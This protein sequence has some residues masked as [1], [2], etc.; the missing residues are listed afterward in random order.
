MPHGQSSQ[1]VPD[2]CGS[3][4]NRQRQA[5]WDMH[6]R[7]RALARQSASPGGPRGL[8]HGVRRPVRGRSQPVKGLS[9][10]PP[11]PVQWVRRR[12]DDRRVR[13]NPVL[14]GC[15]TRAC[16]RHGNLT[17]RNG[18]PLAVCGLSSRTPFARASHRRR[19]AA[20]AIA[21]GMRG[22]SRCRRGD[23]RPSHR[24]PHAG[25]PCGTTFAPD[26]ALPD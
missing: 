1:L 25:P 12:H 5:L 11:M 14:H 15:V 16:R 19:H 2:S 6:D 24:A 18:T 26:R 9:A 4:R 20:N 7:T 17:G 22:A 10:R 23:S 8:L 13:Q 3:A 21:I